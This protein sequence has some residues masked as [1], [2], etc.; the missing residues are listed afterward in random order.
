M[1]LTVPQCFVGS[2]LEKFVLLKFFFFEVNILNKHSITLTHSHGVKNNVHKFS[3]LVIAGNFECVLNKSN[4]FHIQSCQS[5][6]GFVAAF[7]H[8]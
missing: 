5:L 2:C 4:L 1:A 7:W 8:L 3:M 6:V